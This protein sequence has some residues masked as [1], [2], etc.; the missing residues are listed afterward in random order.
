MDNY[1][2]GKLLHEG[3]YTRVCEGIRLSDQVHVILKILKGEHPSLKQVS[4]IK[5]EFMIMQRL[6]SPRIVKAY[7]LE[8]SQNLQ[9]LVMEDF[10]GIP[11]SKLMIETKLNLA[12]ALQIGMQA[13]HALGEIHHKQIIHKDIKPPNIIINLDSEVVKITDFGIST[14][15]SREIQQMVN[16]ALLEGTI[17]YI[18]PEQTGRMNRPIDYRTDI[19]SLGVTLRFKSPS[20]MKEAIF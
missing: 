5:H 11:L 2:V 3:R 14:L 6:D 4:Q 16:P 9:A 18:S 1:K 12:S 13:A 20:C 8:M 10:G 19:Y 15:L 7:A 17:A